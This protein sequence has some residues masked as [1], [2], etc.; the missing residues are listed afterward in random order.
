MFVDVLL[1][2]VFDCQV[3]MFILPTNRKIESWLH[4]LL[5]LNNCVMLKRMVLPIEKWPVILSSGV[6]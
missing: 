5:T 3:T 2:D 6:F 1:S 4:K